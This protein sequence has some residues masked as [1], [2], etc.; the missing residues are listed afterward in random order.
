MVWK[1]EA[2]RMPGD[3]GTL[4]SEPGEVGPDI[5]LREYFWKEK[6][7][8]RLFNVDITYFLEY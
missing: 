5:L 3:C 4:P 8:L 7:L 6:C 2:H 1:L